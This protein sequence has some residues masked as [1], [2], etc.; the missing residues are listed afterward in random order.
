MPSKCA[1]MEYKKLIIT[2][3]LNASWGSHLK[4]ESTGG[5]WSQSEKHL[6][7]NLP[8]LKAVFLALQLFKKKYINNL[9]LITSDNTYTGA[10]H[11]QTG[12]HRI[13]R[14]LCSDV[15]NSHLAPSEQYDTQSKAYTNL[16]RFSRKFP[17][18]GRVPKWTYLRP[19]NIQALPGP[20]SFAP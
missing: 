4:Q 17:K 12:W 7:I 18:Y 20:S 8:E 5:V 14:T 1:T 2:D 19:A 11:Q 9:V 6:H 16:H 3:T 10:V 13:S 15:E